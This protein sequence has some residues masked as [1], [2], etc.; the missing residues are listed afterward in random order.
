MGDKKY[1]GTGNEFS[2]EQPRQLLHAYRLIFPHPK[3][4]EPTRATAPLP[5]DFKRCLAQLKLR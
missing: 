1:A 5:G 4:G 3:T 2:L